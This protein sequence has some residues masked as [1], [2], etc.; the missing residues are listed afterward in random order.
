LRTALTDLVGVEHPVVQTG[1]GWVAGAR[2]VTATAEAGG[3]GILASATMTFDELVD[4]IDEVQSRTTRPFGVNLRADAADASDRV[5]LLI[6][7]GVKV[8][9]FALAPKQEFIAR[10]KAADRVVVPSIGAANPRGGTGGSCDR[11]A[12]VRGAGAGRG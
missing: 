11:R 5:D 7:K 3:L 12:R 10:L 4:A 2:L 6:A 1:M 9:S 8:A